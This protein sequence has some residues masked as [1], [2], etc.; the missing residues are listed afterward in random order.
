MVFLPCTPQPSPLPSPNKV[1]VLPEK[2]TEAGGA[3]TATQGRRGHFEVARDDGESMS[4]VHLPKTGPGRCSCL[5]SVSCHPLSAC[6]CSNLK[7]KERPRSVRWRAPQPR[8]SFLQDLPAP[9]RK[10]KKL[11][12][13]G[14]KKQREYEAEVN[15]RPIKAKRRRPPSPVQE[16]KKR[17]KSHPRRGQL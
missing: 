10:L 5:P 17:R 13:R 3:Y 9:S 14:R 11:V 7:A 6:L 12:E 16:R 8:R 2:A 15:S 1:R 4:V